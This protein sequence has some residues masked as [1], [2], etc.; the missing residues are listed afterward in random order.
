MKEVEARIKNIGIVPVIVIE[1]AT[2]AA[3]LAK[4]L[5]AGDV[6]VAEVTY[7]TAAASEA[8]RNMKRS[9]PEMLVGAGTVL[10]VDM[11]KDAIASG[12][13]FIVSPGL[14]PKVV[15]YCLNQEIA[16]IPGVMTPT[17][18][19]AARE[20]GLRTIKF[21]PAQAAGG[22]K[23][24]KAL[25]GPYKDVSFMPTGGINADNISE[26]LKLSCVFACGASTL[27]TADDIENCCWDKITGMCKE[28]RM[29]VKEV[30]E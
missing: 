22:A 9:C 30:R 25:S 29:L 21:F 1:D 20:L 27:A 7:R 5:S 24:L 12:A 15:K 17:E 11:A 10:S 23:M 2:K 26:Y 3:E 13:D 8:I 19:E 6:N 18:I 16:I 28:M 4:A 14:N